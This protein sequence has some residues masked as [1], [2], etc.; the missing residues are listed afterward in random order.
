MSNTTRVELVG[1]EV[2][3]GVFVHA[4]VE[5]EWD[6]EVVGYIEHE[7]HAEPDYRTIYLPGASMADSDI[8]LIVPV[9]YGNSLDFTMGS[10]E[11]H[12]SPEH[13]GPLFDIAEKRVITWLVTS[14]EGCA[15]IEEAIQNDCEAAAERWA[16]R[17]QE[18][19][20]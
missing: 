18:A 15:M 1:A 14:R 17:S 6:M 2:E 8:Y 5:V 4:E 16:E 20:W 12:L 7:D 9:L 10:H 3:K 19:R 13:D 11:T